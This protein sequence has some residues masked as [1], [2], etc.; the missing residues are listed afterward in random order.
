MLKR[1]AK[2]DITKY[3]YKISF[4]NQKFNKISSE[5][6]GYSPEPKFDDLISFFLAGYFSKNIIY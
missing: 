2:E 6:L 1:K 4:S 3:S 5:V